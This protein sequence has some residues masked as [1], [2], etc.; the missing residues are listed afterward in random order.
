MTL[1]ENTTKSTST[2]EWLESLPKTKVT[3][4]GTDGEKIP[5]NLPFY[6]MPDDADFRWQLGCLTGRLLHPELYEV[7]ENVA[8]TVKKLIKWLDENAEDRDWRH[9]IKLKG[10]ELNE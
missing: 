4:T 6:E 10:I 5:E 2:S 8:E 3:F 7:Y 9:E 1:T